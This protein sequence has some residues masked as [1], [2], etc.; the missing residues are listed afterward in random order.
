MAKL[1]T[2]PQASG[3]LSRIGAAV[4]HNHVPGEEPS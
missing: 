1:G 4:V 3:D 2:F